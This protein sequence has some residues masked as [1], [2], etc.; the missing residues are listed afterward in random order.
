MLKG[1]FL[2]FKIY[3]WK[4]TS[5]FFEFVLYVYANLDGQRLPR[6][7]PDWSK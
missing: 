6:F 2:N 4:F 5:G 3:R 7:P 1:H